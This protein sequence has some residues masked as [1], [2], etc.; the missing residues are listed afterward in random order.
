MVAWAAGRDCAVFWPAVFCI[1]TI[2]FFRHVSYD[3]VREQ[4]CWTE[5]WSCLAY[6]TFRADKESQVRVCCSGVDLGSL[7][8]VCVLSLQWCSSHISSSDRGSDEKTSGS[9]GGPVCVSASL[10]FFSCQSYWVSVGC[11]LKGNHLLWHYYFCSDAVC[12]QRFASE[13][14]TSGLLPQPRHFINLV[15]CFLGN[16]ALNKP[17]KVHLISP[18]FCISLRESGN[19]YSPLSST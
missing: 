15:Q 5:T 3:E 10:F 17:T 18:M 12:K 16:L 2:S 19:I 6:L 9:V 14:S 1:Q 8:F 4:N 13:Q 7:R 11:I